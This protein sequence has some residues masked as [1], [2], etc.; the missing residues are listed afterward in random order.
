MKRLLVSAIAIASAF[1][2]FASSAHGSTYVEPTKPASGLISQLVGEPPSTSQ[3]VIIPSITWG[4][5]MATYVA[6]YGIVND[7]AKRRGLTAAGSLFGNA[8][9]SIKVVK[10]DD[11]VQ[12]AKDYV[13]GKSPAF[14]GTMGMLSTYSEAFNKDPRTA[15]VVVLQLSRS[16]GGDCLVVRGDIKNISDLRG[17]NIVLQQNGPHVEFMDKLLR[18]A[19]LSWSDVKI[20]WCEELYDLDGIANDP[21]NIMRAEPDVD[22]IFC[23]YPDAIALSSGNGELS[24]PNTKVLITTKSAGNVIIDVIA[25]RK[26]FYDANRDWVEKFVK[27]H[28]EAQKIVSE[29]ANAKNDSYNTIISMGA[30]LLLDNPNDTENMSGLLADATIAHGAG[31]YSFF[32]DSGNLAGFVANRERNQDWLVEQGFVTKRQSF[33]NAAWGFL[34]AYADKAQAK[35]TIDLAEV[36]NFIG[37][38]DDNGVLMEFEINFEPMES[39]FAVEKYRKDFQKALEWSATY[40]GAIVEIAGHSD[41]YHYLLQKH[42]NKASDAVL[43]RLWQSGAQLSLERASAVRESIIGY[44]KSAGITVN[45]DQFIITGMGFEDPKEPRPSKPEDLAKNR[46]VVFRVISVESEDVFSQPINF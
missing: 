41:P 13:S 1:L 5:D 28:I 11:T 29:A 36:Q 25:F 6:N 22:A 18:D 14:R 35:P 31:N 46:R 7:S 34:T 44:S 17:K 9:L 45:P 8:G 32:T 43:S 38:I 40:S 19:G 39:E 33:D 30:D 26:D 23:I 20:R 12:Q 21:A 37:A 4:P 42:N 10:Q 15:P 2:A 27:A 24:V 16:T 3:P